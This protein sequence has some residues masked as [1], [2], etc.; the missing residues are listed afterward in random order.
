MTFL[1]E[2]AIVFVLH[3]PM[4]CYMLPQQLYVNVLYACELN[5]L[6]QLSISNSIPMLLLNVELK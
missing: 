2:V 4:Q 6:L 3:F 1:S 5:K